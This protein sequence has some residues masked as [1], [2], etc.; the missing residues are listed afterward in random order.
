MTILAI[1]SGAGIPH[2]YLTR[3]VGIFGAT[4]SGKSTTL[5]AIAERAPCPVLILDAKGDLASLGQHLMRPAMRV[6]AM[7]ADL[8]AR[9]LDLSEAQAGALQIAFAWAEDS[10]RAVA[11]LADLRALLNQAL[12]HDLT[13][14]YGLISPVSVAAV[15]RALL[16]LERGAPWVF[17]D[18]RHDPRDTQGITVYA[19]AELTRLPG[20]YGAFVAHTLETL[21]SGLGEVGD[22][23]APGLMVLIDESHLVFDGAT[24]AVTRRIEQITR[25]IRSKGVGLIYVTQSPSDL[26]HIIAGQLATRIQHALRAS[27]PYHHKALKAA[28][29]TMPGNISPA[30]ILGL[31][32]GQAIVSVPDA[33]GAPLPGRVVAVT[34]GRLPM[35]S[36]DLPAPSLPRQ[37]LD[38]GSTAAPKPKP[39]PVAR[40]WWH[41]PA[42]LGAVLWGLV[43][44]G[45][46][47]H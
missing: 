5:G 23:A 17:Q 31:A 3:H 32:T 18:S 43:A 6:D 22:V 24:A 2:Q 21:Y 16:R 25:L 1:G 28:A 37:R 40:P 4:G 9:A 8:I 42:V 27:T 35:H 34:R 20:L 39:E 38:A 41:W 33:S 45:Y 26:P 13:A 29:E 19:A 46:V 7:G 44:L 47:P 36:V 10:G 15:Q 12:Q 11:T 14:A 30:S